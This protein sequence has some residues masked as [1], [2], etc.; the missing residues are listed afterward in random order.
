[1]RLTR[2]HIALLCLTIVAC[3]FRVVGNRTALDHMPDLNLIEEAVEIGQRVALPQSPDLGSAH[4]PAYTYAYPLTLPYYLLGTYGLLFTFG[5][6]AGVFPNPQAFSTF[7]ITHRAPILPLTSVLAL[8]VVTAAAVPA[9]Y[10]ASRKLNPSHTGW[11]AAGLVTFDLLLVQMSHQPRP[12]APLATL[13]FIAVILLVGFAVARGGWR[14]GVAATTASGLTFGV[15]QSGAVILLPYGLAWLIRLFD[16]A[17]DGRFRREVGW[18]AAN[19]MILAGLVFLLYPRALHEYLRFA[20]DI[21]TG[22]PYYSLGDGVHTFGRSDF[23]LDNVPAFVSGLFGYQ[24]LQVVLLPVAF[25]LFIWKLRTDW[26]VLAIG[27]P[28][29]MIN[30]IMWGLY[31]DSAP[32]FWATLALFDCIV[33]AYLIEEVIDWSVGTF[34]LYKPVV[35]S[36]AMLI[37]VGPAA[38]QATRLVLVLSRTDTRTLAQQWIMTNVP[39]NATLI[40]GI[41][42]RTLLPNQASLRQRNAD[43]PGSLN[44]YGKWLLQQTGAAYPPGPSFDMVDP[45]LWSDD[46]L[47]QA[48]LVKNRRIEYVVVQDLAVPNDADSLRE[49]ARQYGQAIQTFCPGLNVDD[50]SLPLE[51]HRG[52]WWRI[53]KVHRPGPIVVV[54]RLSR[55]GQNPPPASMCRQ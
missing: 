14:R 38:L 6:V 44:R 16:A 18:C 46:P 39:I 9:A 20:Q 2:S 1:M 32:R 40:D 7:L 28:L 23:S 5:F 15:L 42:L 36:V 34:N 31:S 4:K 13:A 51:I 22:S 41:G 11:I 35:A 21:V 8:T 30:L 47:A 54:Y 17:R 25:P 49:Y 52:A 24:P 37:I 53:W 3:G 27:L 45:R 48:R 10:V 26:R 19:A 29:P 12:H 43:D 50:F 55:G 33:C